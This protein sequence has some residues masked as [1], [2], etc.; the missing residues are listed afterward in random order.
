[1]P[2]MK[3]D[4]TAAR[5]I[6]RRRRHQVSSY[7]PAGA[8]GVTGALGAAAAAAAPAAGLKGG[9]WTWR[10]RREPFLIAEVGRVGAALI[11]VLAGLGGSGGSSTG[12]GSGAWSAPASWTLGGVC[13]TR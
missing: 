8:A 5:N 12:G 13:S 11:C 1:M 10:P 3:L 4:G 2:S 9:R 6:Q 7:G